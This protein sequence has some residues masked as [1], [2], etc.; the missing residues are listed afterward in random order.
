M[1]TANQNPI[2]LQI[3]DNEPTENKFINQMNLNMN[4]NPQVTETPIQPTS[5]ILNSQNVEMPMPNNDIQQVN[6]NA[7]MQMDMQEPNLNPIDNSV[8]VGV[9]NQDFQIPDLNQTS[10][11]I[12]NIN[13]TVENNAQFD[14]TQSVNPTPIV[15]SFNTSDMGINSNNNEMELSNIENNNLG[16]EIQPQETQINTNLDMINSINNTEANIPNTE[17]LK[18]VTPVKECIKNLAE[19]LQNFG[20]VIHFTEEDLE[21]TSKITIEIEK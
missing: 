19:N 18:D 1:N 9:Q 15:E 20:F 8:M 5:Q 16:Q 11:N 14:M 3:P 6:M 7:K 13:E 17:A 12:P 10:V 2:E 4:E 21:K